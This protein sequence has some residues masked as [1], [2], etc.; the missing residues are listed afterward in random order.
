LILVARSYN[1][2]KG[3]IGFASHERVPPC[4]AS[5]RFDLMFCSMN[6]RLGLY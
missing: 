4:R 3:R 6:K 2:L 1:P 5:T